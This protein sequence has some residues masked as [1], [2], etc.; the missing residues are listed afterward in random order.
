MSATT[1]VAENTLLMARCTPDSAVSSR[2]TVASGRRTEILTTAATLFASSGLRTSM[3]DVADAC[4]ILPGSL[5]H[6]FDSKDGLLIELVERYQVELDAVAQDAVESLGEPGPVRFDE[7]IVDFGR[8][9]AAC[10]VRHRAA[11]MLT[12]YEPSISASNDFVSV[13]RRTPTVVHQAM[14][15]LLETGRAA[16]AIRSEVEVGLLSERLCQSM[17]HHGVGDWY[18]GAEVDAVPELRCRILLHGLALEAPLRSELDRSP[19]ST[20]GER[21]LQSGREK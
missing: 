20:R 1:S 17:L 8:A 4:G 12:F 16:G 9:I 21:R 14:L 19:A 15:E 7:H 2:R 3:K 11:V 13:A 5:Y 10:A 6:H 18:Q